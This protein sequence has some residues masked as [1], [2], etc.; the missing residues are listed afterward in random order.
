M[1]NGIKSRNEAGSTVNPPQGKACTRRRNARRRAKQAIERAKKPDLLVDIGNREA[2]ELP[3]TLP[4]KRISTL[5]SSASSCS[6]VEDSA[7][8]P[9]TL[10]G[11]SLQQREQR[12]LTLDASASRRILFG[13][14][15]LRDSK[16]RLVGNTVP[17]ACLESFPSASKTTKDIFANAYGNSQTSSCVNKNHLIQWSER[18]N[19]R[20][21]ECCD[22]NVDLSEPP[23][24]FV[25]RWGKQ[26]S[27][28]G[29]QTKSRKK[30]KNKKKCEG[31]TEQMDDGGEG[32]SASNQKS[33]SLSRAETGP[34]SEFA[35]PQLPVDLSTLPLLLA[36]EAS[37]GMVIT[38][39]RW[40]LS[41]KTNW[42]PR[43]MDT[44]ALILEIM[45]EGA[46][47]QVGL[48]QQDRLFEEE[49]KVYDEETGDR[50]YDRFEVPAD[51]EE[52]EE[53]EHVVD[54]GVRQVSFSDLIEPRILSYSDRGK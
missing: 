19:Y 15:G 41:K 42:Q 50:V 12:R 16:K 3:A 37:V 11:I 28:H 51:A 13:A 33:M 10:P 22:A 17:K 9:E 44:T 46:V 49:D 53:G 30:R 20:A 29:G 5:V 14:L 34:N 38:W 24:P 40:A 36:G 48:S 43:I 21:V 47:I 54:S 32:H 2:K 45:D 4:A 25:Q 35:L 6:S 52:D 7:A 1:K 31:V 26:A 8:A 18:I 27:Q 23:F 39:K